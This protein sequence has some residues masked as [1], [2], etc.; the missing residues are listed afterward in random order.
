MPAKY[1]T[2]ALESQLGFI[3][4]LDNQD[5]GSIAVILVQDSFNPPQSH[6]PGALHPPAS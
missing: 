6:S 3:F 4:T 1:S 5:L 2:A